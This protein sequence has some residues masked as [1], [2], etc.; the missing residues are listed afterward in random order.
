MHRRILILPEK[1][2]RSVDDLAIA[3]EF[4]RE[5]HPELF[6][7]GH[8]ELHRWPL[9]GGYCLLLR[10]SEQSYWHKLAA[11]GGTYLGVPLGKEY[12]P[13]G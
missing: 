2:A 1:A 11:L 8:V 5:E 12:L 10:T 6:R 7:H 13:K 9:D 3:E 4:L